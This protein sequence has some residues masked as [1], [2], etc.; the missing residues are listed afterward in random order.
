[1]HAI[2]E[3]VGILSALDRGAVF[4]HCAFNPLHQST[5][6]RTERRLDRLEPVKIGGQSQLAR[7]LAIPCAIGSEAL[8]EAAAHQ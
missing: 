7:M 2:G 4:A 1:L 5:V 6:A 8:I 3:C